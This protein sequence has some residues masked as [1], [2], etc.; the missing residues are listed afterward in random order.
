MEELQTF[1]VNFF[2]TDLRVHPIYLLP[3]VVIGYGLYRWRGK[4]T[5]GNSGFIGWFFPK[6][7][8]LHPSHMVDLKLFAVGRFLS[9]LKLFHM[10]VVQTAFAI[11][12]MGFVATLTGLE[13]QESGIT[14]PRIL[15]ATL[16]VTIT[17]DFCTYWVHRYHHE[18]A[19]IWPF[20]SVHHS[21]EVMTPITVYRKH[22]IYD[23][24]SGFV[25]A[26]AIGLVQGMVLILLMG[27]VELVVIAGIN[28]AYFIFNMAGSNF[29]HTHI[30]LSY[31]RM[32][33]HILIS[34]AQHQI[35]HSLDP[36]H[37]NKNYGELLAIWDW[38]FGTLYIPK[39]KEDLKF[40][41]SKSA[42]SSDRIL[43]PH[44]SLRAAL[45]VPI[46]DSAK[47]IR[48]RLPKHKK[49]ADKRKQNA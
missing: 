30:W 35:H 44:S 39:G 31:G 23:I 3:F 9:V 26:V 11:A 22:P 47:A 42:N 13:M 25:K 16:I 2:S 27:K 28:A 15:M 5:N 40:G 20:H 4:S 37:H 32:L 24:I 18:L 36:K 29:R 48:R 49:N 19:I 6:E 33:E 12:G 14:V 10:G 45:I 43:Q 38:M 1:F 21:A 46:Q 7:I 41:I 8:Y 34:P 17:A